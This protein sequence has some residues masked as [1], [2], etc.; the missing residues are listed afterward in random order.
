MQK[1]SVSNALAR[2]GIH[3]VAGRMGRQ[4]L[5]AVS[6]RDD[7]EVSAAIEFP[8]V[9]AI[10]QPVNLLSADVPENVSVQVV[11]DV[12]HV[13]DEFDVLIDFTRPQATLALLEKLRERA[14]PVVIGTTGFD[15]AQLEQLRA[16]A[17]SLPLLIA[18]NFSV[19]VNLA[20]EL[21][22]VTA[23]ALAQDFDIEIIEAH[24]RNKVDAPS[25]TALALGQSIAAA[26]DRDLQECAVY[27][28]EG[29]TGVRSRE[30]IGF[31]TIRGGDIIGDH[32][33]LFA[34]EG[35]RIEITHKATDRMTFARGAVRAALWLQDKSPGYYTMSDVIGLK[36]RVS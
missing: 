17:E 19:G 8:G 30:T 18:P 20:L 6:A 22:A 9:A 11:D 26:L 35:E 32:T 10:A 12:L 14:K 21:V 36:Q 16:I 15:Q 24:H 7:A 13:V 34:G 27:G 3:G 31:E 28:R 4:L 5:S 23:A 33:V 2:V 1:T 25:G 29:H